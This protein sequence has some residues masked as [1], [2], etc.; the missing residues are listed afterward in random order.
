MSGSF[1]LNTS[2]LFVILECVYYILVC[3][4]MSFSNRLSNTSVHSYT[5]IHVYIFI[6][7]TKDS[8]AW[9]RRV[10]SSYITTQVQEAFV[11]SMPL[12]LARNLCTDY[13]DLARA[14]ATEHL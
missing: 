9:T 7:G 1:F 8:I 12:T 14:I 5:Y 4:L 6:T 11:K 10:N 13:P 2:V 3:A